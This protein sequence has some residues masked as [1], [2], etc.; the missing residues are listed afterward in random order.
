MR[1]RCIKP[2]YVEKYDDDGFFTEKYMA[3]PVN[4]IWKVDESLSYNF[5]GNPDCIHLD[6]VWK[7]KNAKSCPFI[8]V[9]PET[10]AEYFKEIVDERSSLQ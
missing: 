9:L 1:Y 6:R 2:L 10:I 8:E 5:L 3:I 7:S 4:S